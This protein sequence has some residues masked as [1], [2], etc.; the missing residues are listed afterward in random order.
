MGFG[1]PVGAALIEAG[2]G[3]QPRMA[4]QPGSQPIGGDTG[5]P[6]HTVTTTKLVA[7]S[8]AAGGP[9]QVVGPDRASRVVTLIA[10]NVAFSIFV[11][12]A[13][14]KITDMAL[15]GGGLPYDIVLPGLQE[16]YAV[17]DSPTFLSLRIQ[18]A[19][20]LIGDRERTMR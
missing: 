19:P 4:S 11:G 15:P 7:P 9:T 14:V 5:A 12:D 13:G 1:S 10:P 3:V 6:M 2:V 20:L 18:I 8:G 17:T 16:L